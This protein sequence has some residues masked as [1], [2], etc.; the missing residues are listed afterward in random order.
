MDRGGR[1]STFSTLSESEKIYL[2]VDDLRKNGL[3]LDEIT[4]FVYEHLHDQELPNFM[5]YLHLD[6]DGGLDRVGKSDR[7]PG[8]WL[9]ERIFWSVMLISF[10]IMNVAYLL[11]SNW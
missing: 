1:S 8:L 6:Q 2:A 3:S 4:Q 11:N 9:P 5:R 10:V 7:Y